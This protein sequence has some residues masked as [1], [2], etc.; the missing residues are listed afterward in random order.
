[1]ENVERNA[2]VEINGKPLVDDSIPFDQNNIKL[3][4]HLIE[5]SDCPC[6]PSRRH[7]RLGQKIAVV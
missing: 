4:E 5:L 7:E 2:V 1:M 6:D 3:L